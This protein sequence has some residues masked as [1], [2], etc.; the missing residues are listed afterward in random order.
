MTHAMVITAVH[1]NDDGKPVRFKVENSWGEG[2]GDKGF[3]VM[4]AKWFD[5]FVYQVV[6]PH[7]LADKDLVAVLDGGDASVLPAWDP[8]GSLA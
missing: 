1:L 4:T 5:E 7:E 3:F 2:V 6:V 8:M